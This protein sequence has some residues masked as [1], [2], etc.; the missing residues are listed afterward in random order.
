MAREGGGKRT[1]GCTDLHLLFQSSKATG[2]K[3]G[4]KSS[5]ISGRLRKEK[6]EKENTD[7]SRHYLP[8]LLFGKEG[9]KGE[10]EG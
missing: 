5:R 3:G 6:K 8:S 1:T 9:K 7:R 2:R 4:N 10:G